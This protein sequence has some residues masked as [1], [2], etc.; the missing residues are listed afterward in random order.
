MNT[1]SINGVMLIREDRGGG[2]STIMPL[3]RPDIDQTRSCA[4]TVARQLT[5]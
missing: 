4:Q 5:E 1:T 2:S 3:Q